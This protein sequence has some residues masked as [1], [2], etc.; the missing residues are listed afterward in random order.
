MSRDKKAER[1]QAVTQLA[2][3]LRARNP[4]LSLEYHEV[5]CSGANVDN[6]AELQ[7]GVVRA[8]FTHPYLEEG[9]PKSVLQTRSHLRRLRA[10]RKDFPVVMMDQVTREG[11]TPAQL[12]SALKIL[13]LWGECVTFEEPALSS[14][15][16]LDPRFLGKENLSEV[17][18]S[19]AVP[20]E[21]IGNGLVKHTDLAQL[22]EQRSRSAKEE[23]TVTCESIV[24]LLHELRVCF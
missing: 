9:T 4:T 15:V 18:S 16:I 7:A 13:S 23:V 12:K 5:S 22:W 3:V 6:I 24:A 20:K 1:E 2:Q 19:T 21:M 17:F 11:N 10:E 14:V 8:V